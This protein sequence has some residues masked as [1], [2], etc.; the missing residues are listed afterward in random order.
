MVGR[1]RG[2]KDTSGEEMVSRDK[3]MEIQKAYLRDSYKPIC[4]EINYMTE[5]PKIRSEQ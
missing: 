4:L 2:E 3:G 5:K 1:S